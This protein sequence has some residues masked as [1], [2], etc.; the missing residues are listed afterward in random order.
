[1]LYASVLW[2]EGSSQWENGATRA[3]LYGFTA[4]H[5]NPLRLVQA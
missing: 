2:A 5:S 4:A 3:A 1:M